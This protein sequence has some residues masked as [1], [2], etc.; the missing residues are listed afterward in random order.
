LHAA[1]TRHSRHRERRVPLCP[2]PSEFR[3]AVQVLSLRGGQNGMP[4][5]FC[6]AWGSAGQG[7]AQYAAETS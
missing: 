6:D 3:D 2:P 7:D 4:P 5:T 1:K